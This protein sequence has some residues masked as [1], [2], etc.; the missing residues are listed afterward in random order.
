MYYN[1]DQT[2][3]GI[4]SLVGGVGYTSILSFIN[5]AYNVSTGKFPSF[6]GWDSRQ[7]SEAGGIIPI[8]NPMIPAIEAW[9]SPAYGS[10]YPRVAPIGNNYYHGLSSNQTLRQ[11]G[12]T[13]NVSCRSQNLSDPT[14][15]PYTVL[16]NATS[17]VSGL[18]LTSSIMSWSWNT[19]CSDNV[20]SC[21]VPFNLRHLV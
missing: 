2:I 17:T 5:G 10:V 9:G 7:G 19:T 18:G 12:L 16:S 14:S 20:F 3:A 15:F 21:K 1:P 11:Q 8:N 4:S 6:I 13:A